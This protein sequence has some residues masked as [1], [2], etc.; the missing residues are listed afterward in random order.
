MPRAR[1]L[2]VGLV[3]L[4]ALA[5]ATGA[6]ASAPRFHHA[7]SKSRIERIARSHRVIV[8]LKRQ[9]RGKLAGA[10]SV[11]ARAAAQARERRPLIARI[12]RQGGRVTR[13]FTTLNAFAATVSG[14][15]QAQLARDPSVA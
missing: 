14:A 3:A 7:M 13:Q 5:G 10:S 9:H 1:R 11:R 4:L 8:V 2:V 6:G 15:T 12:A